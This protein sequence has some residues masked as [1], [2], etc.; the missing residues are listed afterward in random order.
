MLETLKKYWYIPVIIIAIVIGFFIGRANIGTKEVTKYV[1][2]D[3]IHDSVYVTKI[4]KEK[5]PSKPNLPMI[6]DT[7]TID[8][9]EYHFMKVDTSKIISEYIIR[10][11]Y[12]QILFDNK[13]DGSVKLSLVVQ[14][15]KLDSIGYVRTPVTKEITKT[16]ERTFTPFI[17]VSYNS[18]GYV[19]AGG[20]IYIKN[21]G[22][23]AQY[24]TNF[25]DKG[26]EIS[27]YIKF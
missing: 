12:D 9:I 27:G 19:G 15:N 25:K 4:V 24:I 10:R 18:F 20:G 14:Y 21:I 22:V 26:F 7:V 8:S 17:N 2:G 3:P 1:K 11:T 5:I 16:I 6:P 23:G 13:T